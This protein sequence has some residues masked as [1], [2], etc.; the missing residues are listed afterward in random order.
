MT[1]LLEIMERM[2]MKLQKKRE[3]KQNVLL[4]K[5][6]QTVFNLVYLRKNEAST[7]IFIGRFSHD[8]F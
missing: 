7:Q 8:G 5:N 3:D 2:G 6:K 4:H 1:N